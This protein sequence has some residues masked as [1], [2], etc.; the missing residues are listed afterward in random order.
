D[1]R[2]PARHWFAAQGLLARIECRTDSKGRVPVRQRLIRTPLMRLRERIPW[3][4]ARVAFAEVSPFGVT[5][6]ANTNVEAID[7]RLFI[8]YDAGRPPE[9]DAETL[10][11]LAPVGSNGEWFQAMPVLFEPMVS[12]AAHPAS[13]LDENA[14]YFVNYTPV[15][16][17]D[18]Q[19]QVSLARWPLDGP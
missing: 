14:L 8:G 5:N 7:G 4:F 12:V 1:N 15:P 19:A 17:P 6:L 3:L 10:E 13:A 2:E 11:H 18:G 9:V 16:S